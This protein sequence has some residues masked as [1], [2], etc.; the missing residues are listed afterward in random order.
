MLIPPGD[1]LSLEL[2]GRGAG[3]RRIAAKSSTEGGGP[4]FL[5]SLSWASLF[6]HL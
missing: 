6:S 2:G 4:D 1:A 3:P 5:F